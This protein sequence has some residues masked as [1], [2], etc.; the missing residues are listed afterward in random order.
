MYDNTVD[1]HARN[2]AYVDPFRAPKPLTIINPSNFV[3]QNGFPVVK[4]L[5][6][7]PNNLGGHHN[8]GCTDRPYCPQRPD[9]IA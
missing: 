1:T 6:Q 5:T 2:A 8:P 9:S 3:P 7:L 4:G